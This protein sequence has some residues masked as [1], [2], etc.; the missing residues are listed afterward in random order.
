MNAE[1]IE[2]IYELSPMQQ[3]M[4][5]H[6]L[7]SPNSG[8]YVEQLT[9]ALRGKLNAS[10][11]ER[12]WRR[13]VERHAVLRTSFYWKELDKPLQLVQRNVKLPFEHQDWRALDRAT[14]RERFDALVE[15]DR[16]RGFELSEAP[17]MRLALIRVGEDSYQFVWSH[18]HL[19]LDGWCLALLLGEVF[20]FYK[21]FDRGEEF[22]A[23][24]ARP[25]KEYIAWLQ[26]Q[27][28]AQAESYWR[29]TLKGFTSPTA[30]PTTAKAAGGGGDDGEQLR[31]SREATDSLMSFARRHQLTLNTMAQGAWALLLSRYSGDDDVV[32]GATVSGRPA[33]LPGV[34][35]MVGLFINTLP[36]RVRLRGDGRLLDWLKRLQEQQAQQ[37]E[38]E[39]SPLADVQGWSEVPRGTPLFESIVVFE[40][41]PIESSSLSQA[42]SLEIAELRSYEKTN[43][44][45]TVI[46]K[47]GEELSLEIKYDGSKFD[48]D[49]AERALRH[50]ANLMESIAGSSDCRLRELAILSEEERRQ[51][52]D[53]GRPRQ[54]APAPF[55]CIHQMFEA[56][57]RLS[58]EAI[59]LTAEDGQLSYAELNRRANQLARYLM[60]QGVGPEALV[61][62]CM[63]RGAGMV[64]GILAALKA[65]G[66]YLPLD[67]AYPPA[68]L[69]MMVEDCAARLVLTEGGL[70][71]RIDA[72]GVRLVRIDQEW[73]AISREGAGDPDA[74]AGADN[75]AY[76]IYTSGSTGLPKGV[77]VTHR[78]VGRL[79]S[80]TRPVLE[81]GEG[82]V[83]AMFH[84]YAFD[85]SVWEMWGALCCG[86]R[87]VVVGYEA[88]RSP[89]DFLRLMRGEGVTVLNQTPSA[90]YQFMRAVE[91]EEEEEEEDDER[92][93][94]EWGVARGLKALRLVILGGEELE[95]EK[96]GRWL[97]RS[98]AG[99]MEVVNMYGITETTVHVTHRVMREEDVDKA[100]GS[101]IG[102]AISDVGL[103]VTD[104]R[105]EVQ[106]VGVGGEIYV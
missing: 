50:L 104:E 7:L 51:L 90:Y 21:A 47:P 53:W 11:L 91:E 45:L 84:S 42:S 19:L 100:G 6:S 55:D 30:L 20:A 15:E 64:V 52:L 9:C 103:Y 39:Y 101:L 70:L 97:K 46:F 49:M 54:A 98:E 12:A 66:A 48:T 89:K 28:L 71:D 4:L 88:S 87:L 79:M 102:C 76:V 34:E 74:G 65:G 62:I 37:R 38:Y 96:V 5:F 8:M 78:N 2:S 82:D 105:M 44:P 92:G 63:R 85:F 26:R 56:Q 106:P 75:V 3:G 57:A 59:A 14:Q 93:V 10:A 81:F 35:T 29:R 23:P 25:F 80:A 17:L 99:G 27:D 18:H 67:P 77:M 61:G 41:Y 22:H 40:N 32:F 68:R 58:P 43:Y 72:A 13:V 95:V 24:P 69:A 33:E 16:G 83:W 1:N 60:G 86:G 73:G 31:L 36:V 94:G